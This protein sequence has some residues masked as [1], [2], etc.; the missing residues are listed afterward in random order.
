MPDGT[1]I[2][3]LI[4]FWQLRLIRIPIGARSPLKVS[5]RLDA[6][7]VIKRSRRHD[8]LAATAREVRQR[9][10]ASAAERGG[11]ASRGRKIVAD[12]Q[13]LSLQPAKRGGLDHRVAGM[14]GSRRLPTTRTMTMD[15][16]AKRQINRESDT[17]AEA[18][19][20]RRHGRFARVRHAIRYGQAHWQRRFRSGKP[21]RCRRGRNSRADSSPSI[22]GD[23][24]QRSRKAARRGSRS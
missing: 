16:A 24:P 21:P 10:A 19:A 23:S 17:A 6:Q 18:A 4:L 2:E 8:G 14:S 20:M 5:L 12:D 3:S 9:G 22:A 7:V 11:E 1:Q 15:K 13:F